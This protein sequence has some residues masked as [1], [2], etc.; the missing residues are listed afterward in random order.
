[1]NVI[2]HN[3]TAMNAGRQMNIVTTKR[4]KSA[5]KLSSGYRINRA[6]DDVAGLAI[7]EKMRW[8]LRGLDRGAENTQD[9]I[10]FVQIG[11]GAMQEVHEIVHRMTELSVQA[12]NAT[13]SD[14]DREYLDQEIRQ[15]KEEINRISETTVFN[16]M[17]VFDNHSVVFGVEG[18]PR[19]LEIYSASYDANQNLTQYGGL[20]FHNE[21]I[22]WDKIDPNMVQTD[23]NTGKQ[24][25]SGGTYTFTSQGTGYQFLIHCA[26]GDEL[27]VIT[28]EITVEADRNGVILGGERF[29]W[30]DVYDLN[31]KT[32]SESNLHAGPWAINYH[33]AKFTF[34]LPEPV[35][36]IESAAHDIDAGKSAAVYYE[37]NGT[38][39]QSST[40]EQAVD[41]RNPQI[42]NACIT[43][44]AAYNMAN[45]QKNGLVYTVRADADGIWLETSTGTA[46]AGSKKTW[47]ALGI[48]DWNN[49]MTTPG[50]ENGLLK[51]KYTYQDTNTNVKFDFTLSTVTSKDSV[52]DGLD[53]MEITCD[54]NRTRYNATLAVTTGSH[55]L[56]GQ[57]TSQNLLLTFKDELAVNRDFDAQHWAMSKTASS[58]TSGLEFNFSGGY[59]LVEDGGYNGSSL[60]NKVENY[61]FLV[62][63]LKINAVLAGKTSSSV[64]MADFT[65]ST[66]GQ[67]TY[68][69]QHASGETLNLKYQYEFKDMVSQL[70]GNVQVTMQSV[71]NKDPN[72]ANYVRNADG[73]Y[74]YSR[75]LLNQKYQAIEQDSTLTA[76]Q[77]TQKKQEAY[78]EVYNMDKYSPYA[79]YAGGYANLVST[80][81]KKIQ[82]EI[83]A[84]SKLTLTADNYAMVSNVRG[85]EQANTTYRPDYNSYLRETPVGEDFYIVHSGMR[86]DK[87]GI[88]RYAMNTTALGIAFA[89]CKTIE[90]AMQ[91]IDGTKNALAYVSSKRAYYGAIQNRLEHT[92]K[93]IRNI[94]ENT[95]AAESRIRD[96]DM[97]KEMV[98]Y[99]M[100]RIVEQVG[101]AMLAQANQNKQG[102]L[103][104]LG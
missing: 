2:A 95:Q 67:F 16:E 60:E 28:R 7:S 38:Y 97:S 4:A 47:Q 23:P 63:K 56:G 21:R 82:D 41:V 72:N 9:G 8:M 50:I 79:S 43:Q 99:S 61:I 46:L 24:V 77:K 75:D 30:G 86:D 36:D 80:T 33:G 90:D 31:G 85:D 78:N 37:W 94:S 59:N 18:R 92:L 15:L 96:T 69:L 64:T 32:F 12:A 40:P 91:T 54:A 89:G 103:G 70:M 49:G 29:G 45:A 58:K 83:A 55:V 53:G 1:M 11:D 87:T 98:Q 25:F 93:N 48:T 6:A 101:Q 104:L 13:N 65:D 20:L 51:D 81:T 84:A 57:V 102:I 66:Q 26:A 68:N 52:I 74:T 35:M 73:T 44:D 100:E 27:P 71:Y 39:G 22:S 3:M 88:P 19:D 34:T 42:V 10:S 76:A 14:R 62:E 17:P 5:E